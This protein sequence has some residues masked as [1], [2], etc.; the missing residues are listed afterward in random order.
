VKVYIDVN[1]WWAGVYRGPNHWYLCPLPCVVI[2]WARRQA[3]GGG[4]AHPFFGRFPDPQA[5]VPR[6]VSGHLAWTEGDGVAECGAE[7]VV[8]ADDGALRPVHLVAADDMTS[9]A[10]ALELSPEAAEALA[11]RLADTARAARE[12]L[13]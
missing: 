3:G 7:A 8:T 12:R 1:D 5:S 13:P 4:V 6:S 10:V 2:R 11:A 9:F